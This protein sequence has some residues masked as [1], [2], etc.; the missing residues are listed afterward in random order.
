[1]RLI[2]LVFLTASYCGVR[3]AAEE[4]RLKVISN[5]VGHLVIFSVVILM[6]SEASADNPASNAPP[7]VNLWYG[8]YQT[9][10]ANGV[11][12]QWVNILGNV[13]SSVGTMLTYSLNGAPRSQSELGAS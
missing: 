2:K 4:W 8:N 3:F 7:Q 9:F 5:S 11:P 1:M 13:T 6:L 12:Q 10:G